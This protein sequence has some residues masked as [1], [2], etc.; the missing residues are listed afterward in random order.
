MNV[1]VFASFYQLGAMTLVC[2][3]PFLPQPAPNLHLSGTKLDELSGLIVGSVFCSVAER[4]LTT[5][6]LEVEVST[7]IK[8]E[9]YH[10]Y[11]FY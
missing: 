3:H 9:F 1:Q 4:R 2:G 7:T 6:F 5:C 8:Q 11:S 10:C